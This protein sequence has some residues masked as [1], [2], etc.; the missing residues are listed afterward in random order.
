MLSIVM[1][2]LRV[3]G[4]EAD[5]VAGWL[6]QALYVSPGRGDYEPDMDVREKT[7]LSNYQELN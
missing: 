7:T 6:A 5:L 4:G 1:R 3:S 2:D